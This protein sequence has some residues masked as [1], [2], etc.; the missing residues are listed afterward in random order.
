MP[1]L[2]RQEASDPKLNAQ[3][4]LMGRTHFVDPDTLRFHKSRVLA[5]H[6]SDGGLL[7][8]VL[9]SDALDWENTRRGYRY[10]VFDL[11]GTTVASLDL[12]EA[13]KTRAAASKAMWAKLNE[14][15]AK[16]ITLEAIKRVERYHAQEMAEL[17][18]AVIGLAPYS[19]AS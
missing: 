8:A 18:L 12:A 10:T 4:N 14:L 16:E 13:F 7:C 6:I 5:F 15:D 11:F 17:R 19:V 1:N 2:Y 9:H 3:R